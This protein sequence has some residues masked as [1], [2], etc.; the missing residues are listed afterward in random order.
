[1]LGKFIR[2]YFLISLI[3][4]SPINTLARSFPTQ[5]TVSSITQYRIIVAGLPLTQEETKVYE[6]E[7]L[8]SSFEKKGEWGID[9]IQ[10]ETN[11]SIVDIDRLQVPG[12]ALVGVAKDGKRL[13]LGNGRSGET[14]GYAQADRPLWIYDLEKEN[15]IRIPLRFIEG[16][17]LPGSFSPDGNAFLVKTRKYPPE[18]ESWEEQFEWQYDIFIVKLENNFVEIQNLT[19]HPGNCRNP[20]WSPNGKY[21]AYVVDNITLKQTQELN[22][23][24]YSG[25]T[26]EIKICDVNGN[27]V[28]GNPVTKYQIEE[29][30]ILGHAITWDSTSKKITFPAVY[31]D[32]AT[33][34]SLLKH[35]YTLD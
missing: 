23:S 10:F 7:G 2:L 33:P 32:K 26:I 8:V 3:L 35:Y 20:T 19:T 21:I 22:F 13:L 25:I 6:K 15:A 31:P 34:D 18:P 14:Y 4:F 1:M 29:G 24:N 5:I 27:D 17:V 28:N 12:M 16:T 30:E 11:G 9:L